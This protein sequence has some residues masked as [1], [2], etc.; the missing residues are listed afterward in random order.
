MPEK[1]YVE[2]LVLKKSIADALI[3]LIR[4]K[5]ESYGEITRAE[6]ELLY[7]LYCEQGGE[8]A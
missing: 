5:K 6:I 4:H 1:K 8:E 3:S 7:V 2:E